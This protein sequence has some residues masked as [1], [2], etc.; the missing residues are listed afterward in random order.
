MNLSLTNLSCTAIL[1]QSSYLSDVIANASNYNAVSI[2]L[3]KNCC[4]I[5][6]VYNITS[7][8]VPSNN[9]K[10][11]SIQ[12]GT[13]LQ[14]QNIVVQNLLNGQFYIVN[15]SSSAITGCTSMSAVLTLLNSYMTANFTSGDDFTA[16]CDDTTS[17]MQYTLASNSGKFIAYSMAWTIPSSIV[18]Q[19]SYFSN[20]S[21]LVLY[22]SNAGL[23]ID[24]SIIALNLFKDS[25]YTI[26]I[27][28]V[29]TDGTIIGENGCIFI[30]CN[31][32]C[33]LAAVLPIASKE[34]AVTMTMA[35][36]GLTF[37][38]S[39]MCDCSYLCKLYTTL[40]EMLC[41]YLPSN[42]SIDNGCGCS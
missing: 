38:Q 27:T 40:D 6:N 24:S 4:T 42:T 22:F 19:T 25:L 8:F 17:N 3:Q 32:Q 13:G 36:Y 1:A 21:G 7:N 34:D 18:A 37:T 33:K 26:S 2:A 12:L 11:I 29:K 30:N 41:D 16:I 9:K 5:S 14:I 28:I 39:C 23:V 31:T 15:I 35:Y 20:N 10:L